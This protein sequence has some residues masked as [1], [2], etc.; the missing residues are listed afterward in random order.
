MILLKSSTEEQEK[1]AMKVGSHSTA[2]TTRETPPQAIIINARNNRFG[3]RF[4]A[5]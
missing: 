2:Q 5:R 1:L 4:A 3:S